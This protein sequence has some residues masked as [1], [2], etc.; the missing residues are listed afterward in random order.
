MLSFKY[1]ASLYLDQEKEYADHA[2]M[3]IYNPF[4]IY[5]LNLKLTV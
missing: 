4:D 2:D 1:L 3:S 5:S